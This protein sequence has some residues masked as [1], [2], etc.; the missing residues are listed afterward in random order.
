MSQMFYYFFA[1]G[2]YKLK[3]SLYLSISIYIHICVGLTYKQGSQIN[4]AILFQS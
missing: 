4:D 2:T 1:N 3:I